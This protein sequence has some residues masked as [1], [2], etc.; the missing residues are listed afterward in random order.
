MYVNPEIKKIKDLVLND[1]GYPVLN[2]SNALLVDDYV[3]NKSSYS[4]ESGGDFV[5]RY[6]SEHKGDTSLSS[7]IT[8]I[9]LIDTVD[10]TNLKVHLGKDYYKIMAK[11]IIDADIEPLIA[12]GAPL[13]DKF[14]EI[15]ALPPKANSK[16]SDL[17]L[18]I[19]LSKYITRVNQYCYGGDAYSIMDSVVRDN[20]PK[21]SDPEN[22]IFIPKLEPMRVEYKF[23]EYCEIIS[24]ILKAHPGM[25]REALDHF[26]WFCFKKEAVGDTSDIE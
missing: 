19:F 15:A 17:N 26:V 14:R 8:K 25:T 6:F 18:F 20:L 13:G 3:K 7:V 4:N 2:T 21:F 9:I 1:K 24:S 11:R 16:K 10:S 22:G 12:K 5:R 23:D